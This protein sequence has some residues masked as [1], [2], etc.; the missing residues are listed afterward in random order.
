MN[1]PQVPFPSSRLSELVA[2]K[3]ALKGL[4]V[5]VSL[6]MDNQTCALRESFAAEG[7]GGVNKPASKM[8]CAAVRAPNRDLDFLKC[9]VW[10]DFEACVQRPARN[11]RRSRLRPGSSIALLA[12]NLDSLVHLTKI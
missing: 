4:H 1:N 11:G 10:E 3:F 12:A 6:V 2:A 9:A 8:R 5:N 7:T